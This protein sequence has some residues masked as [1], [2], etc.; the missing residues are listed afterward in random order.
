MKAGKPGAPKRKALRTVGE[1]VG[2]GGG[3][4]G[5]IEL[6]HG[7][8]IAGWAAR[9]SGPPGGLAAGLFGGFEPPPRTP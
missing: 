3:F 1:P 6:T 2:A 9:T 7:Q 5:Y 4:R 8:D